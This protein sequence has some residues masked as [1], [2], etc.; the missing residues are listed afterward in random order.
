MGIVA[1]Y[2][3]TS[4]AES[5]S[6]VE[7]IIQQRQAGLN[8]VEENKMKYKVYEDSGAS[9]YK[10]KS[11]EDPFIHRPA[12]KEML[13][14]I[15]SGEVTEVWVWELSRLARRNKFYV[16]IIE[17]LAENDVTVW[18]Q[19]RKIDLSDPSQKAMVGMSGIF[20]E[21]ERME[22]VERTTRG[23]TASFNA[24][25]AR[26]GSLY[27][28]DKFQGRDVPNAEQLSIVKGLFSDYLEGLNLRELGK[29]YFVDDSKNNA[30]L[31]KTVRKVSLIL[32]HAEHTG[33]SLKTSGKKIV[34]DFCEGIIPDLNELRKEEHWVE[35]IYYTEKT[36]DK[37][38][39]IKAR[40]KIEL[41]RLSISSTKKKGSRETNTSIATGL[42]KCKTCGSKY[43]FKDCGE[44]HGGFVYMHLAN[45]DKC[46]Q[47]PYQFVIRK[48]DTII[49][50]IF[51]FYYLL[52]DNTDD[53][54]KT[55][56]VEVKD[57]GK[58]LNAELKSL[59]KKRNQKQGFIDKVEKRISE[60]AFEDDIDTFRETMRT[61]AMF[62]RELADI[63]LQISFKKSEL[64]NNQNVENRI[65]MEERFQLDTIDRIKEWFTLR[66]RNDYVRLR[67]L[68]RDVMFDGEMTIEEN[69][70]T[71]TVGDP[72]RSFFFDIT[73]DY[74]I[75]YPYISQ[76]V[77][78]EIKTDYTDLELDYIA[79]NKNKIE[80]F[81]DKVNEFLSIR[82]SRDPEEILGDDFMF[83]GD[84][85]NCKWVLGGLELY[86]SPEAYLTT[87]TFYS[88]HQAAAILGVPEST[89][90]G[91]AQFRNIH[92][93]V[94]T[95]GRRIILWTEEDIEFY[96]A[97][98]HKK[99]K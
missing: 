99:R 55:M 22:I 79:T 10:E 63:N 30:D 19:N 95:H 83:M 96:K 56:K 21:L 39:W 82:L 24:K 85:F 65:R 90:K 84:I 27:G 91:W 41:V 74:N 47:R 36:I 66:Q 20:A 28:Y 64:Q 33:Y 2:C 58:T 76:I 94:D 49:D 88:T 86:T 81:G 69:I 89:L 4:R 50:C 43:Y 32:R 46:K 98:K 61:I 12:F 70:I 87:D 38:T 51:T 48:L 73:H 29:K 77:G 23:K 72:G 5:S 34:K 3:R 6:G 7:T 17:Y 45:V 57:K 8:F 15:E 35:N 62:K 13:R 14:D 59:E 93:C 11:A 75:V 52:L 40:E 60:G 71:A 68:F 44:D 67:E 16:Q 37:E 92:R 97:G 1:I 42:L 53:R 25:G 9:G 26:Y 80:K 18:I 78:W 31:L 54:L